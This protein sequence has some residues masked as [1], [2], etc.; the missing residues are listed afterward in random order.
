M[1]LLVTAAEM[2]AIEAEAVSRG[3]TW[4]EL[5]ERAG[6]QV[7]RLSIL[8]LGPET[9]QRMLVLAGPGNNGGDALVVARHLANHGWPVRLRTWHRAGDMDEWLVSPLK[10]HNIA[11]Q[12]LSAEDKQVV[13]SPDLEWATAVIDGLLGT[14]LQRNVDTELA[15]IINQIATSGRKVIAIDIPTGVDSDTGQVR[16][17]AIKADCTVALGHLKYGHVIQPGAKLSGKIILGE[18]GLSVKTSRETASGELLTDNLVRGMLPVR[19][20]DANKGTFGKAMVVA[21]SVNYIGAAALATEGAMRAGA[22]LVT[23][24]CPGDLLS[25]LAVK[26]TECTFIPLPSDMGALSLHAA[27][28]VRASIE[29]YDALLIGCGLGKEKQTANFLRSLL[30]HTDVAARPS[31]RP[32]GFSARVA[33]K[34]AQEELEG[35]LPPLVLDGDALN[36]LAEWDEWASNLP[37]GTVLT[38]HP[39][40][41]A[42]L[43][44]ITIEEVQK[45][46][47]G[48]A[49]D[50]ASK[51]GAIVVLKG[52]GTVIAQPDGKVYVSPFSNPA[53]ATAGTGDVLAGAIV[54]LIAQ[55][56]SPANAACAGVYLHG[57]SG[58]LLRERYG[59][60]GGLAGELPKLMARAQ[61]RLRESADAERA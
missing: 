53:L 61:R 45:D 48:V 15:S 51:W 10:E 54:G 29:G 55:G 24:G 7:A 19:P 23:L 35:N 28:K 42:R 47:V 31:A 52:A 2:R 18:I 13:L 25:V 32:I 17:A 11:A 60:A 12:V 8:W 4:Q 30:S 27:E 49:R 34:E 20:D 14:G 46:R 1:A 33:E 16:G 43:L 56:G 41:M 40:E 26:L 44:D 58:E 39:G 21:G 38:P 36:L 9:Q 3:A 59:V 6:E 57:M 22:G 50:A 37:K 5:M